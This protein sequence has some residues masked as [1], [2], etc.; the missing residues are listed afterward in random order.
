M[1]NRPEIRKLVADR[2]INIPSDTWFLGTEHNTCN[3]E[4]IWYDLGDLPPERLP[5]LN[6]LKKEI[7]HGQYM[8]AHERCRRLASAPVIRHRN[9]L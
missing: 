5:A 7:R 9:K 2:G 6:K 4:F 3:E 8:S 1:A